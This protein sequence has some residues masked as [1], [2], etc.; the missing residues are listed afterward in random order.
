MKRKRSSSNLNFIISTSKSRSNSRSKSRSNSRSKS[1]SSSKSNSKISTDELEGIYAELQDRNDEVCGFLK[2]NKTDNYLELDEQENISRD[3]S[4]NSCQTRKSKKMI[5]HTH[6][7]VSKS[8]PSIEDIFKI[9]KMK[10]KII[11]VSIIFTRWG[12]WELICNK[13]IE[14][15]PKEIINKVNDQLTNIYE[16]QNNGKGELRSKSLLQKSINNINKILFIY[17][18]KMYFSEWDFQN[19]YVLRT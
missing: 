15:I 19:D 7:F 5:Y 11:K 16:N 9:V 10:N 13:K 14:K 12:I 2:S 6:P 18:F 17:D 4:R 3:Y 1:R 8:Y